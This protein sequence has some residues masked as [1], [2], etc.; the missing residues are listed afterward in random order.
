[1]LDRT[2][3][4]SNAILRASDVLSTP[5]RWRK[6]FPVSTGSDNGVQ[7]RE[8][9]G[10]R[11]ST[12]AAKNILAGAAAP[13]APHLSAAILGEQKWRKA[14]IDHVR[15]LIEAGVASSDA[16]TRIARAGIASAHE[17]VVFVRNGDESTIREALMSSD[18]T[19]Q[20]ETVVGES[21]AV[22]TLRLPFRGDRLGGSDLVDRVEA[23]E[24]GNYVE[25]S[26]T[27]AIRRA[28]ANPEWFDL[29]DVTVVQLGAASEM[30]PLQSLM[31]WGAHVIAV[32]LPRPGLWEQIIAT[33]KVGRGKLSVPVR[34]TGSADDITERA[35]MD[36][37]TETPRIRNWLASFDEDL[38]VGNYVYADGANFVRVATA[39]DALLEDLTEQRGPVPVS[40]LATP[41]DVY[42]VP[43]DVM[44]AARTR[45]RGGPIGG[46][47]TA[48]RT[49]TAG[50]LFTPNYG[51]SYEDD[52]GRQWGISDC[53]VPQQ[54]ANYAL[55]KNIQRWRAIVSRADGAI[56]SANLAPA[57]RTKS[58][59]K[60][61]VLAAAYA[62]APRFGVEVF[63]SS[64]SSVLMAALLVH[65][66]RNP[67]AL[68]NPS[69]PIDHPYELLVDGAAHGGLLRMGHEPR[70]ILPLA[71]L[72]GV[73]KTS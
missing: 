54:G 46:L 38:V 63:A 20:T 23:W 5:A 31:E 70:S 73:T 48:T 51:K 25:P 13:V 22:P 12:A 61:R 40:Y 44:S 19:F 10:K 1:M 2:V 11:S 35:G 37:L 41:T 72:L 42:A 64:T 14:Y 17:E 7:F 69:M 67:K 15:D 32:D 56:T 68:A 3:Y 24:K 45:R 58:V 59:V 18:E 6:G 36:L 66:L 28:V 33:A 53:L 52:H 57:T 21:D 16:A 34:T 4:W 30:G 9:E 71:V 47:G 26:C 49:V 62:G 27:E 8:V 65:D 29:S 39:V 43:S 55:A 60:N 50:K